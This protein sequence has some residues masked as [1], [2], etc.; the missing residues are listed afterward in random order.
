[1]STP[2][3][4]HSWDLEGAYASGESRIAQEEADGKPAD[5]AGKRMQNMTIDLLSVNPLPNG[6]AYLVR[7][8]PAGETVKSNRKNKWLQNRCY[9]SLTYLTPLSPP[10]S[11]K[12]F[13]NILSDLGVLELEEKKRLF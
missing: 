4:V 2:G 7:V 10:T 1:M 3:R 11:L 5:R 12:D 6:H 13:K 8:V 9:I